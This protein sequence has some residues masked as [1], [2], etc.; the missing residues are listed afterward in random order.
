MHGDDALQFFGDFGDGLLPTDGREPAFSFGS[1]PFQRLD[2]ALAMV[3][4]LQVAVNLAAQT[5]LRNGMVGMS[6][7]AGGSTG[8]RVHSHLPGAGVGAVVRANAGD[9]DGIRSH[10]LC[11]MERVLTPGQ[12]AGGR[13][14][15]GLWESPPCDK[16]FSSSGHYTIII[17]LA[18]RALG[19]N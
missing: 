18:L 4:A 2:Q 17:L 8:D 15:G 12:G 11:V 13:V 16:M 9:G 10:I 14:E 19:P 6:P 5:P 1:D 3:R 7:D